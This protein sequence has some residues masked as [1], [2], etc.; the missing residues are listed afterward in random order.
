[1]SQRHQEATGNMVMSVM[2]DQDDPIVREEQHQEAINAGQGIRT[3]TCLV[4]KDDVHCVGK[5]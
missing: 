2:M 5:M 1:M 3:S 4:L